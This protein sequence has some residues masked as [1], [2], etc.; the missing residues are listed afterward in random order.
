MSPRWREALPSSQPPAAA[1][2]GQTR[3][4]VYATITAL[5]WVALDC[6]LDQGTRHPTTTTRTFLLLA[7]A[8][9][10]LGPFLGTGQ[11]GA[12]VTTITVR[13]SQPEIRDRRT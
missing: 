4:A 9:R 8:G 13:V 5:D 1:G 11:Q 7:A 10:W 2:L 12:L 6:D 3:D